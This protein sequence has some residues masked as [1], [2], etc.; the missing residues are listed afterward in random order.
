[1]IDKK[2]NVY[3]KSKLFDCD[4][5]ITNR[6]YNYYDNVKNEIYQKYKN[7][8]NLREKYLHFNFLQYHFIHTNF[9]NKK[10]I[11][12]IFDE[13]IIV[14]ELKNEYDICV[15]D[16]FVFCDALCLIDEIN[17]NS[18]NDFFVNYIKNKNVEKILKNI[19]KNKNAYD[20]M[21]L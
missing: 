18:I 8:N 9:K 2:I 13:N 14:I 20:K 5:I 1:M 7:D 11:F 17:F 16:F 15:Y 6:F 3:E 19:L 10:C 21:I 4:V 12:L